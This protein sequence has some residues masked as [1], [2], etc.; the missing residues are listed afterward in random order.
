MLRNDVKTDPG[1]MSF[2]YSTF[3]CSYDRSELEI[4]LKNRFLSV[5]RSNEVR[6]LSVAAKEHPTVSGS[7]A[8]RP[9]SL[10]S[11]QERKLSVLII[12]IVIFRLRS[13]GDSRSQNSVS[14]HTALR[15]DSM[16]KPSCKATLESFACGKICQ[17]R[18][19]TSEEQLS[20]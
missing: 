16:H 8:K 15:E 11:L 6:L 7:V 13:D 5:F 19:R 10:R 1:E 4:V 18:V 3:S 17:N 9:G 20:V 12:M 14:L 2:F